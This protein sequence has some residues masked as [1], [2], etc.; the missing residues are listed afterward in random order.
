MPN[1][2][3]GTIAVTGK[4][5]DIEAFC[6]LFLFEETETPK[7][8]FARSFIHQNWDD[9]K[10]EFSGEDNTA[11]SVDFA[12][13]ATSCLING[14]P[15]DNPKTCLTLSD[16]CK[17]FKVKVVIETEEEGIGFEEHI[18]CDSKGDL[19]E[20]CYDM[21]TYQCVKCKSERFIPSSYTIAEEQCWECE[22][23]GQWR[24][25]QS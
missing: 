13:S 1:W 8:Y 18:E 16:A 7:E 15:Q 25:K 23:I 20:S 21:P 9:F 5:T 22:T 2:A 19:I 10:K 11:F 17:K 14:Y 6:K 3:I 4:S 12:W 24:D